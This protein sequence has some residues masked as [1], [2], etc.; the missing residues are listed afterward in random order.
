M[1]QW[2]LESNWGIS[3]LSRNAN[4]I[5]GVKKG[6]TWGS[7]PT[8]TNPRDNLAYRS[9]SSLKEY[10]ENWSK[11][12]AVREAVRS[13]TK[14]GKLGVP[15]EEAKA[16]KAKGYAR[17]PNYVANLASRTASVMARPDAKQIS[18]QSRVERFGFDDR[19]GQV[20]YGGP[21][22]DITPS[23]QSMG[24]F[25]DTPAS[26]TA[27]PDVSMGTYY[28]GLTAPPDFSLQDL[29]D[30]RSPPAPDWGRDMTDRSQRGPVTD[31][32]GFSTQAAGPALSPTG[33]FSAYTGDPAT[34]G[35]AGAAAYPG[36]TGFGPNQFTSPEVNYSAPP[37][38]GVDR[39]GFGERD[40]VGSYSFGN[41]APRNG[42]GLGVTGYGPG[43][44][45]TAAMPAI[46]D[47]DP[48]GAAKDAYGPSVLADPL[49]PNLTGAPQTF[50]NYGN[51]DVGF[52]S[53][54][55]N[56][57]PNRATDMSLAGLSPVGVG[58]LGGAYN[59]AA[60]A[61]AAPIGAPSTRGM[62]FDQMTRGIVGYEDKP[63]TTT[64][65]VPNPAYSAWE[66][67]YNNPKATTQQ[68][69]AEDL[70]DKLGQARGF[71]GS[72]V[73]QSKASM[74]ANLAPSRTVSHTTTTMQRS[75]VYGDKPAIGAQ[76]TTATLS[77]PSVD[78]G[79]YPGGS[80]AGYDKPGGGLL[81]GLDPN[82]GISGVTG[83][84]GQGF[85][86]PV[87]Y[88]GGG[89]GGYSGFSDPRAGGYD[90]GTGLGFGGSENQG[91]AGYS[92][93]NFGGSQGSDPSGR[94]GL[95]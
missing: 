25:Y 69:Y 43:A 86:D 31:P 76:P 1:G 73:N 58:V 89:W 70:G 8:Y 62:S 16:L 35:A 14:S 6:D 79:M 2:S 49:S 17:D 4:N 42:I 82:I 88:S 56:T 84:V 46:G 74:A 34:T 54:G 68:M 22:A 91:G 87:G 51:R 52:P 77:A 39:T 32:Y 64:T 41:Q 53:G 83:S 95:Y 92:G 18:H 71:Q 48:L 15:R 20:K 61:A 67:A 13:L 36:I 10:A 57:Q 9:Y 94:G 21:I 60:V 65:Q 44:L 81:A 80:W 5:G 93:G 75:P 45:G 47:Y 40:P 19:M 12:K 3:A 55:F 72:V 24:G 7:R 27:P 78:Y 59:P 23:R 63:V 33:D 38:W 50:G 37:D 11:T 85:G 90:P 66:E 28:G 29:G 26:R 30:I